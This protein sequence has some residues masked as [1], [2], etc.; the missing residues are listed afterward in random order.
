MTNTWRLSK[1]LPSSPLLGTF[2]TIHTI[3]IITII[4]I[5]ITTIVSCLIHPLWDFWSPQL[6]WLWLLTFF[7]KLLKK[8][9]CQG[10]KSIFDTLAIVRKLQQ[11]LPSVTTS[12][13]LAY[14]DSSSPQ[15]LESW[16]QPESRHSSLDNTVA[17][18]TRQDF[19]WNW[20]WQRQTQIRANYTK[21]TK[22]GCD[23][24]ETCGTGCTCQNNGNGR[25]VCLV[26]LNVYDFCVIYVFE[27]FLNHS[28]I[29]KHFKDL[30]STIFS[31]FESPYF[32]LSWFS[33]TSFLRRFTLFQQKVSE[34]DDHTKM[35]KHEKWFLFCISFK[36]KTNQSQSVRLASSFKR[37][38]QA[39]WMRSTS[40]HC[41]SGTGQHV[42]LSHYYHHHHQLQGVPKNALSELPF[43]ETRFM[44]TWPSNAS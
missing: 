36:L 38:L 31:Q 24:T 15:P 22:E 21:L 23:Q 33:G 8:K 41:N 40:F 37:P 7:T 9:I 27:Y 43:F 20:V 16:F 34:Y 13:G 6:R 14:F 42:L 19:D 12:I 32:Y 29:Q 26:I 2:I 3:S 25:F 18:R 11:L 28:R 1:Q 35:S 17:V 10:Q 4:I 39:F 30:V 5:I 44:G